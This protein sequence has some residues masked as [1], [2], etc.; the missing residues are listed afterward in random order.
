M[1]ITRQTAEQV[2]N[3]ESARAAANSELERREED[4]EERRR[5]MRKKTVEIDVQAL[6]ADKSDGPSEDLS[7]T[8]KGLTDMDHSPDGIR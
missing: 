5:V 4:H 2:R 1:N 6:K 3:D 8:L 7:G